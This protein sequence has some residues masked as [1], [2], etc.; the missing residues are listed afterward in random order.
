MKNSIFWGITPC[1][2]LKANQVRNHYEAGCKQNPEDGGDIFLR[3]VGLLLVD[4]AALYPSR[5]NSK[6]NM[7]TFN[8]RFMSFIVYLN[9]LQEKN[10]LWILHR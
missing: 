3:N 2:P 7:V 9:V 5:Q 10:I 4:Y 8:F 6:R 1:S